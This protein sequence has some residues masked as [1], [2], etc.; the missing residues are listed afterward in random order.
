M[1]H[2]LGIEV[3]AEPIE[4]VRVDIVAV[5]FFEDERPL[6]G[7]AGRADWRL[8]GK[9]SE[10]IADSRMSGAAGEAVLVTPR[11]ALHAKILIVL[12]LGR[13]RD[14]GA[15]V[16]EAA[17]RDAAS[18][19][20]SLHASNVA[21]PLPGS[22]ATGIPLRSRVDAVV[23]GVTAAVRERQADLHLQL[24]TQAREVVPV[25]EALRAIPPTRAAGVV[26]HVFDAASSGSDTSARQPA[27]EGPGRAPVFPSRPTQ[28]I[29]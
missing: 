9:L 16:L 7:A 13:S 14:F 5:H 17:A 21:L 4:R 19:S 23:R 12:G 2:S 18:R 15:D 1:T 20:L 22:N 10:L 25:T 24:V 6:T 29:K 11:G 27:R 28:V 26:L 8:G 3:G